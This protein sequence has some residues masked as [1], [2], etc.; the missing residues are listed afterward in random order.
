MLFRSLGL[1][2]DSG[3]PRVLS[4]EMVALMSRRDVTLPEGFLTST[5]SKDIEDI[6]GPTK[7]IALIPEVALDRNADIVWLELQPLVR[8]DETLGLVAKKNAAVPISADQGL[9]LV[10]TDKTTNQKYWRRV[11]TR[12]RHPRSYIEPT[13]RFDAASERAEIRFKAIQPQLVPDKGIEVVGRIL[14]Q[15]PR[16]TEMK[17]AGTILAGETLTLYCQVPTVIARELTLEIDVDGFP[18]AF[19]IKVPCWRTN[20]DI[21]I[22]SDFQKI[23]FAE[24]SEGLEI[25]PKEQ[26]QRVRLKIDAIPGA[27]ETKRDYVEVGWDLDRDREFANEMTI[28]FAAE[29]QVEVVINSIATGRIAMT[30]N[31]D[32]I[33]FELPPPS[34]KNQRV[35][36]LARLFA[37]GEMIWSKP[38]EV[39]ADYDPPTIT[40][41]EIAPGTTFSQGI[42]LLV[43]VGVDDARL[44]GIA[45][46]EVKIDSKGVSKFEDSTDAAKV[47]SRESDGSWTLTM[48]T[49]ELKPGRATLFVR[50]TDRVGNNSEESKMVLSILSE[51]DWQTKLKS[52]THELSGTVLFSDDPLPNAKITLEDEKGVVVNATK[53]DDRGAFRFP[54]VQA[55][56]YKVV[57]IGVMKNR[58]RKA[59]QFVDV[60][61]PLAPPLR[62]RMIAK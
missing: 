29:R 8:A 7:L 15:L 38:I 14:E 32:D 50:A 47:C 10:F 57:A 20:A 43:R 33:A 48:P 56:K 26:G 37:G 45:S 28:K 52:A 18:R 62:L 60:G 34:L 23:E 11:S 53:T 13:V 6:L 1:R 4:V 54:K 22:V 24:P 61:G 12:V 44:S 55:G 36:L 42:D 5:A 39:I 27:F 49:A 35:N 16:G 31:V 19:V 58:P 51:Q 46:V 40:G 9:V 17:L 25:G 59:E 2:N 21:P 41:V 3:K 30:A